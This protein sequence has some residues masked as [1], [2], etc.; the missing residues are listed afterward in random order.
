MKL[1]NSV[2]VKGL[3]NYKQNAIDLLMLGF[4]NDGTLASEGFRPNS[5]IA[6]KTGTFAIINWDEHIEFLIQHGS[7]V[8]CYHDK[9][10]FFKTVKEL[11]DV[12]SG[13]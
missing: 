7:L 5:L 4:H 1:K 10:L 12:S 2:I 9:D 3:E 11:V 13:D 6:F 8:D